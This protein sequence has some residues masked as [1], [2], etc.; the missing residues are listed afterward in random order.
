METTKTDVLDAR[1]WERPW[2]KGSE[3]GLTVPAYSQDLELG[4]Q[5]GQVGTNMCEIFVCLRDSVYDTACLLKSDVSKH[6]SQIYLVNVNTTQR[7]QLYG[8]HCYNGG[9]LR[10][11]DGNST[12]Y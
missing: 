7:I 1:G 5:R 12:C 2:S 10:T 4:V 11:N 8:L 6:Q 3:R 9:S